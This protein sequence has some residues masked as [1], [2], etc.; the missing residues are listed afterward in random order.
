M[1]KQAETYHV[2]NIDLEFDDWKGPFK[3][4]SDFMLIAKLALPF[5]RYARGCSVRNH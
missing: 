1:K 2:F 3:N 4:I 5:E